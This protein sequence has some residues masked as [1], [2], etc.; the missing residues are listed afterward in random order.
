[1]VSYDLQLDDPQLGVQYERTPA[2]TYLRNYKALRHTAQANGFENRLNAILKQYGAEQLVDLEPDEVPEAAVVAKLGKAIDAAQVQL[3]RNAENSRKG[4]PLPLMQATT[5][6]FKDSDGKPIKF[7][8]NPDENSQDTLEDFEEAIS[9]IPNREQIIGGFKP[10]F[11][12]IRREM[13]KWGWDKKD[14]SPHATLLAIK[15][16]CDTWLS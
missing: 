10:A 5:Y 2:D 4:G 15:E 8:L 9:E 11:R 16:L 12:R 14:A 13:V 6:E 3:K 1:M 7:D